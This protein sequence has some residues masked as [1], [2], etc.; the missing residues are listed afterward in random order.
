M[1]KIDGFVGVDFSISK[2]EKQDLKAS[3][4][5]ACQEESFVSMVQTFDLPE[6]TLIKYTSKL[7]DAL[8]EKKHCE[9]CKGLAFCRNEECG[10]RYTPEKKE[11]Q[12]SFSYVA[13][14]YKREENYKKNVQLF[15]VNK[16]IK[17][18]SMSQIYTND[19][20]RVEI[21]KYLKKYITSY[22]SSS[23]T[24]GLYL[25]GSFGVGKTYLIAALFNELA[26]RGVRSIIIHVP[27][28]LRSMKESFETG[29][30][31]E[32]FYELQ[33]VPLLLLDD[34]GAE[35]LTPWA[36]D[37][38]LEPLLQYRMEEELPTF[39]TSNFTLEELEKHF[40]NS[41]SGYEQVKAKRMTERIRELSIPM[42]LISKNMRY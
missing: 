4:M 19:K 35:Y 37:E 15:S 1:K 16:K 23:T 11:Q 9:G 39:F 38:I 32:R 28:L 2:Q 3:F 27:E 6:D 40:A 18:A 14:S 42:E 36:R 29:D 10:Y 31:S 22:E 30:Y 17:N 12:L 13:C 21:I 20:N 7:K 34:I 26:K 8:E 41:T 33:N 5:K 25:H 24:K